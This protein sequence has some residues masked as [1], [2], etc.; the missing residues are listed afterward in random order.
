MKRNLLLLSYLPAYKV[1]PPPVIYV[2][3]RHRYLCAY[4]A[5]NKTLFWS[6]YVSF[7]TFCASFASLC[8]I[9]H[10]FS[11]L[12][13]KVIF[14]ALWTKAI[15]CVK[16][17]LLE[18]SLPRIPSRPKTS[19]SSVPKNL[20]NLW[21]KSVKSVFK[22]PFNQRNPWL[23]KDLRSTKAYVRKNKLFLQIEPKFR[24]VKFN[25]NK[26]LTKDYEKWTLGQLGKTNPKRTQTN[27]KR[28]Q[29]QKAQN[30]RNVLH[31]KGI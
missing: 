4:K 28:T 17:S 11:Q 7:C 13:E 30:E 9:K 1:F 29:T 3:I 10:L 22:N 31:Y 2:P 23:I 25:V 6:F 5:P 26:V 27:P 24:K 21:L 12:L 14:M 8:L 19:V 15:L 16:S 18:Q 20:C